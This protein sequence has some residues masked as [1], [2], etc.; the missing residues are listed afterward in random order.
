ML[1]RVDGCVDGVQDGGLF[2]KLE[3]PP[4]PPPEGAFFHIVCT[5]SSVRAPVAGLG[6]WA[7]RA[8]RL[9]RET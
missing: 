5:H 8:N 3:P 6:L 2:V 7:S 9:L 4:P 1:H